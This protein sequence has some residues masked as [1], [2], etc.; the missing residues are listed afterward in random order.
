MSVI[1]TGHSVGGSIASLAALYFLCSSSRP[2]APSPASLLCITFG[3]PLLGDETLSR[4]IL[5]ERWGG[6]FC[7]VVSQH[8]IM[9]RLL[10][11]PVNA[12]HPR[13]A[14]SICSLMQSWHLSMRYPQFPRP[15]LQLTDDQ[16]AELQGHISMHIGAAASEQTQHISPYRPFGNYVL[17]SAEGAVCI[18]DPLVAAKMLHLTFTTG[19][20]SISFEEQHISYGDLVVQLPQTLQSKRRLHLEEDAPKSNH[21]AGVSLALEAS[22]IGIQVDH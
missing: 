14:M 15:A 22:G 2:D 4:A 20:A 6:R 17:C 18:D 5:R 1:F 3:S 8:D 9:P 19:S 10:F 7:H 21:S 11:C 13:L 16:K 12:V